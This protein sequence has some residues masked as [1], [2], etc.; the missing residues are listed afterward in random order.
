[1]MT[2]TRNAGPK[3]KAKPRATARTD[4][5]IGG[6]IEEYARAAGVG[7]NQAY[8]AAREGEIPTIKIGKRLV[9]ARA[10]FRQLEGA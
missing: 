6:T 8:Q 5:R 4:D 3:P 2:K 9:V 7:V 10:A 1:M